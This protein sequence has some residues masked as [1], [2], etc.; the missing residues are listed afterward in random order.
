MNQRQRDIIDKVAKGKEKDFLDEFLEHFLDKGL[1]SLTKY[2]TDVFIFYLLDK[3]QKTKGLNLTNYEWST[4]LKISERKIKN[5]R[6]EVGIRY[7]SDNDEDDFYLWL[8][9]LGLIS[10]GYLEFEGT[11]KVIITIENP[12]LLR[13]IE[14]KLKVLKLPTTDYSFNSER[15]KLKTSSLESLL[16]TGAS[17]ISLNKDST[18]AAAKLKAAKWTAYKKEAAKQVFD[19]LKRAMPTL[20]KGIVSPS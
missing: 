9:L 6:L 19:I 20:M 3:Y 2:E 1:G 10:E 16:T 13:F 4:L 12:Y 14:H 8:S 7:T 5:L 18:K 11:D 15:V 17:E